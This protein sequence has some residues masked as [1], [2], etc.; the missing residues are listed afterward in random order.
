MSKQTAVEWL[1]QEL[2][3]YDSSPSDGMVKINI[4]LY[5]LE[6]KQSKAKAMER[7]QRFKDFQGGFQAATDAIIGANKSVQSKTYGKEAGHE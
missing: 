4:P 6:E 5:L 1:V 3:A 2:K 7:E